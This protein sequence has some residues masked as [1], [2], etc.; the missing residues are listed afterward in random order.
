VYNLAAQS[1]VT[2]S[3]ELPAL[4]AQV[5][6]MAGVNALAAIRCSTS[7]IRFY[8]ASSSEMFGL[9][10][11]PVL[12]ETTAFHPRSPYGVAKAFG[13][14]LAGHYRERHGMHCSSVM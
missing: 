3:W 8:Q 7:T 9:A 5:T 1:T 2:K 14:W 10:G 11:K 6:G 13:H 4:T 12:D